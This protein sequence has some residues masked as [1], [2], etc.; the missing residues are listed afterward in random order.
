MSESNANSVERRP[1]TP[2]ATT[3]RGGGLWIALIAVLGLTV[4]GLNVMLFVLL[5]GHQRALD[6]RTTKIQQRENA[7]AAQEERKDK[8]QKEIDE[9]RT[10][11]VKAQDE[12]EAARNAALDADQVKARRDKAFKELNDARAE[13]IEVDLGIKSARLV[14]KELNRK[15]PDLE[16][17]RE[18]LEDDEK[19]TID[20]IAQLQN[21]EESAKRRTGEAK[22][23][24][25]ISVE[26]LNNLAA[27]L[28]VCII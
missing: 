2:T 3:P 4:V 12:E 25:K 22:K 14:E 19:T 27:E 8:L 17:R 11:K 21:D 13:N 24:R 16:I 15:I 23:D 26:R 20:R 5:Q 10:Q 9:L 1:Q 6:V 28:V 18:T 7:V